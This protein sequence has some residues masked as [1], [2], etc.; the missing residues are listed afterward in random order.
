M[1]RTYEG[2]RRT[3]KYFTAPYSSVRAVPGAVHG[4]TDYRAVKP[5]FREDAGDVGVVV[6]NADRDYILRRPAASQ[7]FKVFRG[8]E[9]RVKVAGVYL[10]LDVEHLREMFHG[11]MEKCQ[12]M[13]PLEV[14]DVL[15]HESSPAIEQAESIFEL[16]AESKDRR[17]ISL[18][19]NRNRRI[20][21]RPPDKHRLSTHTVD[22]RIVAADVDFPVMHE[23]RIRYVPETFTRFVVI[24]T[25]RFIAQVCAGHHER[26]K[27][28][29]S[30]AVVSSRLR[31]EKQEVVNWRV[32]EHHTQALVPRRRCF[33][34]GCT[35]ISLRQND[36]ALA[37][38]K[39]A[40]LGSRQHDKLPRGGERP[41][42]QGKG[43]F[44]AVFTEPE[45]LHRLIVGNICS[46]V[47]SAQSFHREN[48]PLLQES[49][50]L[51]YRVARK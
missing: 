45:P 18:H 36:R 2:I 15:A 13:R 47:K 31:V 43:L 46:Q 6:L 12:S 50:S 48:L 27:D 41:G 51:K 19:D 23:K 11:L 17:R 5:V 3:D 9:I 39:K 10:G 49:D 20:P 7:T 1:T 32:G 44:L 37:A 28:R 34:H 21:P 26:R 29:I 4:Q 14:P 42:H 30:L 16:S 35:G 38:C 40:L 8:K 24:F 22:N 25:D 33:D